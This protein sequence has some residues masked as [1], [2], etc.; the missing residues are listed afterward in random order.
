MRVPIPPIATALFRFHLGSACAMSL[1][2]TPYSWMRPRA[3][4]MA[5]SD[6]SVE[7]RPGTGAVPKPARDEAASRKLWEVSKKLT[8]V[9]WLH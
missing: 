7:R 8:R 4:T 2:G 6:V 1:V 9:Q 5:G 3:A